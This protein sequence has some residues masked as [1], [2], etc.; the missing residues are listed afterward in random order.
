MQ[1][2][3][4]CSQNNIPR[5]LLWLIPLEQNL[6]DEGSWVK[7]SCINGRVEKWRDTGSSQLKMHYWLRIGSLLLQCVTTNLVARNSTN[8]VILLE[9]SE[10]SL[11]RLKSQCHRGCV[12]SSPSLGF[13]RPQL[14]LAC[15]PSLHLQSPQWLAGSCLHCATLTH[16]YLP[17][18]F[19]R[20]LVLTLDLPHWLIQDNPL[21][22]AP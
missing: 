4:S 20:T 8:A 12:L 13:Q 16:F 6:E 10:M 22:Q 2:S 18:S 15:G 1:H 17:H 11:T 19:I 5:W 9:G 7:S 21:S 3:I 14:S